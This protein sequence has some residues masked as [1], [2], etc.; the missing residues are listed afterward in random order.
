MTPR[1]TR[2][3]RQEPPPCGKPQSRS[4]ILAVVVIMVGGGK[5]WSKSPFEWTRDMTYGARVDCF[6]LASRHGC[7]SAPTN[8]PGLGER[9]SRTR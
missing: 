3:E 1:A 7:R 4:H 8:T 6:A 9:L 5:V 2:S